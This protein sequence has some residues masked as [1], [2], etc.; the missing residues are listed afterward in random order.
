MA[1]LFVHVEGETEEMFVNQ[2]LRPHLTGIG[3]H[4]VSAKLL[5]NARA[6]THRGGIRKWP[7]VR[8]DILRHLK[9]D[10]NIF[11]T[12]MVDYYA[13]PGN[14]NDAWPGRDSPPNLS[15]REKGN[16]VEQAILEDIAAKMSVNS[17]V[18]RFVPFVMMHE[19]EALLFSNCEA[20]ARSIGMPQ[21]QS[22]LD[23]IRNAFSSPEE[24]NDSPQT[25]PSKRVEALIPGYQKPLF[26]NV[27]AHA[28]GLE[29]IRGE[30]ENF[31]NWLNRLERR[32]QV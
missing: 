9:D 8:D 4:N 31:A 12:V 26:G 6:R 20:F 13:L 27:A 16:L 5:G 24:I 23:A 1:R 22:Q 18:C 29:A 2:I 32:V 17:A 10:Q 19:F 11:S 7:T 28:I 21:I 14:G 3:Y 25:A 30:C 15:A